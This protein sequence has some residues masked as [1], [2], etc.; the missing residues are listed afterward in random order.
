MTTAGNKSG[1]ASAEVELPAAPT[2]DYEL[3]LSPEQLA[4]IVEKRYGP[5]LR[6]L[7]L[8]TDRLARFRSLLTE[9]QQA[10]VD[11][12]NAALLVG[13]NPVRE[14]AAIRLAIDSVQEPVDATLRAEFGAAIFSAYREYDQT[15]G[16]RNAVEELSRSLVVRGETL[17]P[18]QEKQL[19][20]IL[21]SGAPRSPGETID[22]AIYG[23]TD[24][25]APV[26]EKA[27][28]AAAR[29]LSP[30][31]LAEFRKLQQP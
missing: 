9:R 30:H 24:V 3:N 23:A 25:R 21:K 1:G 16:E 2:G 22:R 12:A 13:M 7:P 20:Q 10:S 6:T 26:T 14:T 4:G 5:L 28:A 17:R 11:A 27:V 15:L 31:Q 18:E 29:V 19:V 8:P